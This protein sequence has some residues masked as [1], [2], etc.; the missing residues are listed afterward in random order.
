MDLAIEF[1]KHAANCDVMAM[2][3]RDQEMKVQWRKL[4]VHFRSCAERNSPCNHQVI[5]NNRLGWICRS[6]DDLV[7][8]GEQCSRNLDP[9][10]LAVLRLMIK[11]TL[12]A[13]ITGRLGGFSP[14]NIR[15]EPAAA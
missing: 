14:F 11:L 7:C 13:R 15:P 9:S 1:Q 5:T 12:V 2:R 4:A 8:A 6:L 3:T 10:A